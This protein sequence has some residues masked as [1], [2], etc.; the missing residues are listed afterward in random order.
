[1][2]N[3]FNIAV[4]LSL[5]DQFT[6]PMKEAMA[7]MEGLEK[8]SQQGRRMAEMG[9]QMQAAGA[10]TAASGFAMKEGMEAAMAPAV[11]FESQMADIRKVVDFGAPEQF[12][13]MQKDI[14]ALSSEL[15]TS[16][17]GIQSI[18]A[19]AGQSNIARE[20]LLAFAEDAAVMSTAFDMSAKVA[21]KSMADWRAGMDQTQDEVVHL[22]NVA[23]HLSNN[24]NAQAGAIADVITRQGAQAKTAGLAAQETAALSAALL[25]SGQPPEIAATALKNLTGALEAGE[26]ASKRQREAFQALG[27]DVQNMAELMQEDAQGAIMRVFQALAEAPAEQRGSLIKRVFGE[28]SKGAIAP[29]L[30]NLDNLKSAFAQANQDVSGSM[31][32]EFENKAGTTQAQLDQLNSQ[33]NALKITAGQEFLPVLKDMIPVFADMVQGMMA[34]A[35]ANPTLVRVGL[36][37]AAISAAT[38][39]VVGPIMTLAGAF[40][41]VGGN[42]LWAYSKIA[43]KWPDLVRNMRTFMV[44]TK[45]LAVRMVGALLPAIRSAMAAVWAFKSALLANPLTWIVGAIVAVA[46]AAWLLVANWDQVTAWLTQA[47]QGITQAFEDG[48]VNGILHL[49]ANFSPVGLVAQGINAL[50]EYLFGI[51]L[52]AI[53]S[54]FI[55]GLADGITQR[56]QQLVAWLTGAVEDLLSVMPSWVLDKLGLEGLTAQA[57]AAPKLPDQTQRDAAE[58]SANAMPKAARDALAAGAAARASGPPR[59]A[60]P[61]P[62]PANAEQPPPEVTVQPPPAPAAQPAEA[63]TRVA[64][65]ERPHVQPPQPP[66]PSVAV[67]P[68]KVVEQAAPAVQA[69]QPTVLPP[70]PSPAP[71]QPPAPNVTAP[72][73]EVIQQA[74]PAV[75][76]PQPPAVAAPSVQA[77]RPPAVNAPREVVARLAE[78]PIAVTLAEGFAQPAPPP[79]AAPPPAPSVTAPPPEVVQ[80]AA[81]AV[82]VPPAQVIQQAAPSVEAPQPPAVAAPSVQAPP[83][84]VIQQAAPSV[85]APQPPPVA[86]PSVQ[87]PPAEVVQQAAPSVEAP[88]PPPVAAPSVQAPRPPAVNAPSEVVARLAETPVAV[89]LAQGVAQASQPPPVPQPTPPPF[90]PPE[91]I[92][93]E[94]DPGATAGPTQVTVDA[95]IQITIEGEPSAEQLDDLEARLEA[96]GPKLA[97]IVEDALAR[98]RR[99]GYRQDED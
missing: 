89:T 20:D 98:R 97:R 49:L 73:A 41:T 32:A 92:T 55:G 81:P 60:P 74:A 5:V 61:E 38:L 76:A 57:E 58:A 30:T 85:E 40:M 54:E 83:A 78:T 8:A 99:R 21:G 88:Q 18:V 82:Q 24:M 29:L 53:G 44:Q 59:P 70:P 68:P 27:L 66:A 39:L 26:S 1:M 11:Q 42:A 46:A 62:A 93:P 10:M 3:D 17:S 80:Q 6:G 84:E 4:I 69:P 50:I 45:Y 96:M 75:Q 64:V 63:R 94:L 25:S 77:P 91:V 16:I 12:Q 23:N 31:L 86:A 9:T 67:P 35:E 19:A 95:P 79:E 28:E 33:F 52:F 37:L 65:A 48:F 71:A 87:A 34:F 2:G 72:P 7:S 47:W 43:E 13:A 51:D 90:R 56:W 22:A 14:L 36:T 15:P